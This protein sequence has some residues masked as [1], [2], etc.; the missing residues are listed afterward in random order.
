MKK[1]ITG[2]CLFALVVVVTAYICNRNYYPAKAKGN[3]GYLGVI[4]DKHNFADKTKS[5]RIIFCGGSNIAFG[6]DSKRI[7]DSTGI[8]VVNLGLHGSLGLDY[9]INEVKHVAR[10]SDIIIISPE[11]KLSVEGDHR[12]KKEAQRI[13]PQAGSYFSPNFRQFMNDFFIEDLQKN[14]SVTLAKLFNRKPKGFPANVVY[15]RTSFNEYGDVVRNFDKNPSHKFLK[16]YDMTYAYF[17]GMELLNSFKTYAN[18]NNIRVYFLYP[19]FPESLYKQKLSVINAFNRDFE[20]DLKIKLLNKPADAVFPDSLFYDTEYHLI[21][22]GR[23]LRTDK[24]IK[25]FRDA[26]LYNN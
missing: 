22:K 11:Y 20:S 23:E 12:M 13:F 16:N 19:C 25:L 1:F 14:F 5:P 8:P 18:E 26:Y 15:S 10:P 4:V 17:P 7:A 3:D 9:M 6:I 21:P 2:I 24:I